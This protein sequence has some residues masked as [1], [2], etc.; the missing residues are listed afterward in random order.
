MQLPDQIRRAGIVGCGGAGFPAHVKYSAEGIETILIN[1]AECEPLLQTDQYLMRNKAKELIDAAGLLLAETKAKRCVIALKHSYMR[2]IQ[3]L[4]EAIAKQTASISLHQLESFFPAGDEQTIVYEVTGKVVPPGGIPIQV[5]CV[6]SNIATLY[7]IYEAAAGI[8]FTQKYLTVTG[9]VEK[10]VI[11][12]VPIGTPVSEC[13]RLA[14]G[15]TL[16]D[17]VVINGGPMMGKLMTREEADQAFVTKTMSG[18]IVLPA[19]SS[20][21]RGAEVT[22]RQMLNRAKSACIQCSFCT[23]LCPRNLLGHPLEPHRIMRKLAS[24]QDMAEL[25]D[26]PDVRNAA[27]CCE[28]GICE[29]YACPMGLQPR[30]VNSILKEAYA[31]AGIRYQRPEGSWEAMPE[32][33]LRKAPTGRVA[34]RAGV[35][36]Y[37]TIHIDTLMEPE[38][39]GYVCLSLKQ[40]IGAASSPIV[41]NGERV[42]TGQLIAACPEGSLGS[43]LHASIN[44]IVTVLADSIE[45]RPEAEV[46]EERQTE[47]GVWR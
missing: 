18:L 41:K 34:A 13:L 8:P 11:T 10:P 29:L 1:G 31:K 32:R 42:Q 36:R 6:V 37:E 40:G 3:A 33:E 5:G 24:C 14:G 9:E 27:L 45:I 23:Q 46:I 35:K 39:G 21:A 15:T 17:Y 2:E 16:K 19:D 12:K 38:V 4:E 44:G 22:V 25:S 26:D 7:G 20:I 47:K 30:R 28:C 43:E